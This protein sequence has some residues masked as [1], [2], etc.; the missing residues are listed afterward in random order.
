MFHGLIF[1]P[2]KD[3]TIFFWSHQQQRT[4]FFYAAGTKIKVSSRDW[5]VEEWKLTLN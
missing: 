3:Y 2:I 4:S 5:I 1:N